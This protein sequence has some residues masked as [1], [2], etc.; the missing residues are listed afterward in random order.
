MFAVLESDPSAGEQTGVTLTI[1]WLVLAVKY[2]SRKEKQLRVSG[3]VLALAA[4]QRAA[5]VG[6][7][8]G[9]QVWR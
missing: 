3:I 8:G 2:S 4:E 9:S 1:C 7:C 6:F 5:A